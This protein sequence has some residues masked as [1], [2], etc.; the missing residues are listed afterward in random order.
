MYDNFSP[1]A[2]RRRLVNLVVDCI[3]VLT[4]VIVVVVV[5]GPSV[6]NNCTTGDT[7]RY[8]HQVKCKQHMSDRGPSFIP[9][10]YLSIFTLASPSILPQRLIT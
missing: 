10:E 9:L 8:S 7:V 6:A 4:V 2:S 3:V 1:A 5:A